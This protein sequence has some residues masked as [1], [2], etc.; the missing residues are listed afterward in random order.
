M[1]FKKTAITMIFVLV[2]STLLAACGSNGGG[3]GNG[4]SGSA[5]SGGGNKNFTVGMVTDTGGIN[6]KSFNQ[7]AWEGLQK[8]AKDKGLSIGNGKD[9]MYLESQSNSDYIPN[10]T[11]LVHHN[12]DLVYGIGYK[13]ADAVKKIALQNP[14]AHL[15]IIDSVVTK[16]NGDM[17]PNVASI[18]FKEQQGSFLVGIIAAKMTKTNKIGFIG[19][20]KSDVISRFENG[21]IAGAK[22]V[23]PDIKIFDQYAGSFSDASKGKQIAAAMYSKGA[24][25]V[26]PAAGATGNGAFTEAKNRTKN[27]HK[28]WVIGVDRDQYKEGLPEDVTLTSMV[29]HVDKAV[30]K[31]SSEAMNGKFPGGK[32]VLLGLKQNAVGP[33]KHHKHV[34]AKVMKLVKQYKQKI[35]NGKIEVPGTKKALDKY[36]SNH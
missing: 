27:G 5:S 26:F 35:I 24:D 7:G 15:A 14:D 8:F 23:N 21:F 31:V 13:M 9:V 6:D 12:Y 33:S 34:P 25:I 17:I 4:D 10:L 22:T 20:V 36:L 19:G 3:G 16:D 28:V 32:H 1:R 18:T 2:I 11:K 29:K 30:Y